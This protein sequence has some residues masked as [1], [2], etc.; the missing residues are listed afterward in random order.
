MRIL[1]PVSECVPFAKTGGLADVAGAL[2]EA[3]VHLGHEVHLIMPLYRQVRQAHPEVLPTAMRLLVLLGNERLE[4]EVW[5][6]RPAKPVPGLAI[7]FIR[8]DAFFDRGGLYHGPEGDYGDNARRFSFFGRAVME[9]GRLLGGPWD[10]VHCHDWHTGLI[11][12]YLKTLYAHDPA[13]AG[14]RSIMTI[15]NLAYQGVFDSGNMGWTGLPGELYNPEAMEFWGSVNFLKT[16]L[17]FSDWNTTV[18]KTYAKEIQTPE[19]GHGLDGVLRSRGHKLSGIVNGIDTEV[20]NPFKDKHLPARFSSRNPEPKQKVKESL[21]AEQGL[22]AIENAPVMS[23]ISRLDDQKG[24]DI[25]ADVIDR[26]MTLNLQIIIL[27]TGNK[28]YHDLFLRMKARFP[29]KLA[30]NLCFDN[31]LAH[32]IYA[33]SDMFLMP[34]KFEPCGLGQLI[35]MRYGAIPVVRHTGGLADTVFH[36]D[37]H[38]GNGFAFASYTGE[39]LLGALKRAIEV[40]EKPDL[41][42]M[43]MKHAMAANFSWDKSAKE[44]SHLYQHLR[45]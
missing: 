31:A 3:L 41:W 19:Y 40:W 23:L 27:G 15:H 28:K 29:R 11:P 12:A 16:G 37:G 22:Y 17:V 8:F 36:F 43:V 5:E 14:T 6:Y 7:H 18:S 35:A 30:V 26:V 24:F 20:W 13:F 25:L 45:G 32:R 4:A 34:S 38:K 2:P 44:Y 9:F 42:Q 39:A 33:G 1:F 10:I 21:L